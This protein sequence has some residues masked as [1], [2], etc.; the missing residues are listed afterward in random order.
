MESEV[1]L[2]TWVLE[3]VGAGARVLLLARDEVL[4]ERLVS[5]GCTV[6]DMAGA[7]ESDSP[8]TEMLGWLAPSHV[9]LSGDGGPSAL[10]ETLRAVAQAVPSATLLVGARNA[11][12]ST[13]LLETLSGQAPAVLGATEESL[14]R[15]FSS[16]GLKVLARRAV[17]CQPRTTALAAGTEAALRGL[18][19]QLSPTTEAEVLL[20]ALAPSG[21]PEESPA[22]ALV[23]EL[24]SVVLWAGE[25]QARPLLDEA[26]FSLACQEQ[27]PLEV[28]LVTPSKDEAA[29]ELLERYQAIGGYTFQLVEAEAPVAFAE[30]TCHARGQY[31]AFLDAACVVYPDH[32][33]KL[34]QALRDGSA[35]WAVSRARRTPVQGSERFVS[36]K[37]PLPLGEHLEPTHLHQEPSLLFALV[38]DRSRLGPFRLE[39]AAERA[40]ELT[41]RLTALFEPTFLGSIASCEQRFTGTE[42]EGPA[43]PP[44]EL[45]M[46]TSLGA[47]EDRV[48]RARADGASAKGMRHRVIDELNN[49]F[50]EGAP[51]LHGALKS[52]AGRL[53]RS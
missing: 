21:V 6:L 43:G 40:A 45:R 35:A 52:L 47:V 2:H 23:P 49:R 16:L 28:V 30:G 44:P 20:Y 32:Y 33:V 36:H 17:P 25:A 1:P 37:R 14:S 15:C 48:E 46:L 12:S 10:E 34:V 9:V 42:K 7:S 39:R 22:P 8:L 38:V 27:H 26:L 18:L 19:A 5:A 24:L 3:Q 4:A 29:R 13:A 51:R 31:V 11:A 41:L 53:V 50:R